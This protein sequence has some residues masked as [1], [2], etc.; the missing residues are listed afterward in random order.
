LLAIALAFRFASGSGNPLTYYPSTG[1]LNSWVLG[2][3]RRAS[4]A[5]KLVGQDLLMS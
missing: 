4:D 2:Y 1:I 5:R 3:E